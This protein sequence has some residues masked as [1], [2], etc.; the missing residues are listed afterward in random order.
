MGIAMCFSDHKYHSF[1]TLEPIFDKLYYMQF[2][3]ALIIPSVVF[4]GR[5]G[6]SLIDFFRFWASLFASLRLDDRRLFDL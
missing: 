4:G 3:I 2:K 1:L 6:P 5:P